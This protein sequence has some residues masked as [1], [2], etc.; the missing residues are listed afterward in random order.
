MIVPSSAAPLLGKQR[1]D[2]LPLRICQ[3]KSRHDGL[4]AG[5]HDPINNPKAQP[6]KRQTNDPSNR[7]Y[8][9]RYI[10]RGY[11]C[12][13]YGFGYSY[14]YGGYYSSYYDY[15]PP[16]TYRDYSSFYNVTYKTYNY[17]PTSTYTSTYTSSSAGAAPYYQVAEDTT[18][19][20]AE[21]WNKLA[22]G[23]ARSAFRYFSQEA[24]R[25]LDD[26]A[27]KIGYAIASAMLGDHRRAAWAMR[28]AF[29]VDPFSAQ[30]LLFQDQLAAQVDQLAEEYARRA[31]RT[32]SSDADFMLAAVS[33][34]IQDY[35]LA[36]VAI[37]AAI[38][39]GDRSQAA[40]NLRAMIP[41]EE[42]FGY[43][44]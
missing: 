33:F 36:E 13:D 43:D 8:H 6:N 34:L 24:S 29:E 17:Y 10:R 14:R 35:Q 42:A 40:E 31:D 21:G 15:C 18:T 41:A 9:K 11:S 38:D 26:G 44:E 23:D 4:H 25:N 7:A 32:P 2:E 37:D 30:T 20:Y 5:S 12:Y 28:R 1:R 22:R 3:I 16:V 19:P 27:P 39:H